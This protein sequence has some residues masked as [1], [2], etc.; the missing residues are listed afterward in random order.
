MRAYLTRLSALAALFAAPN[1]SV[2]LTSAGLLK[3]ALDRSGTK[4]SVDAHAA[5]ISVER[6]VPSATTMRRFRG[7]DE[8]RRRQLRRRA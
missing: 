4:L 5:G 7:W 1:G 3:S 2:S 8:G 6:R